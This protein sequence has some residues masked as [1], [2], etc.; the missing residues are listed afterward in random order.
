MVTQ[1]TITI[2]V[3]TE[4]AG[5]AYDHIKKAMEEILNSIDDQNE[6]NY[7]SS[8]TIEEDGWEKQWEYKMIQI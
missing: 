2:N 3:S 1:L 5:D 8:G 6:E 7:E 4:V